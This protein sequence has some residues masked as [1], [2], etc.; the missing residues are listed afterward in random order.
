MGHFPSGTSLRCL[1]HYAQ[2][3]NTER[4][5]YFDFGSSKN[6][7]VY[8][9]KYPPIIPIE[10]IDKVPIAMFVGTQDGLATT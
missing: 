6:K 2:I 1:L 3:I 9:N 8:G 7:E 10:T 5:Q 4:F